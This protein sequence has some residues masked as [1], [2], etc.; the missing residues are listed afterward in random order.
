MLVQESCTIAKMTTRCALY[1]W[2]EWA[3]AEIWLFEIIQ[4]DGLPP[5]WIWC[6]RK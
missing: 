2:I 6:N 3:V 4:D 5:N 1:K